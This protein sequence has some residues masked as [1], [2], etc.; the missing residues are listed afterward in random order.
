MREYVRVE[1]GLIRVKRGRLVFKVGELFRRLAKIAALW[2]WRYKSRDH[3]GAHI[4]NKM[5]DGED[6]LLLWGDDF[7]VILDIL[8]GD[9]AVEQQFLATA[10]TEQLQCEGGNTRGVREGHEA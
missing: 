8:E 5:E 9:E 3:E 6:D 4:Q 7:E 10:T 2:G 1:V